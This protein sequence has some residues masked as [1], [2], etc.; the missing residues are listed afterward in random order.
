MNKSY[1]FF[2]RTASPFSNWHYSPFWYRGVRYNCVEQFM[3][4]HKAKLFKDKE[5]LDAIMETESPREQKR[6]G[7]KVKNFDPEVWD[8]VC[9]QI[10]FTGCWHKIDENEDIRLALLRTED[11]IL[12]EASPT[13][14]IWGIGFSEEDALK[15]GNIYRWGQNLLGIILTEIK[16]G[17]S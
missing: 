1:H 15:D 6:L 12:V 5:T 8:S 17:I 14:R 2:Y 13:D 11:K 3:M 7:R 4:A 10:V 9:Q 16:V